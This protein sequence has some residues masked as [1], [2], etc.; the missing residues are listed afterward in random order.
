MT[1]EQAPHVLPF[2]NWKQSL[3][4]DCHAKG[5]LFAYDALNDVVLKLWWDR[6]TDPT[7]DAIVNDIPEKRG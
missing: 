6:G 2:E 4:A 3:R 1:R 5:R 7:V